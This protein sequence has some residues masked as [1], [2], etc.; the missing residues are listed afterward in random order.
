LG[1]SSSL[2]QPL[3]RIY[4]ENDPLQRETF[5]NIA[6][7]LVENFSK[8]RNVRSQ[9]AIHIRRMKELEAQVA[10][11]DSMS[12]VEA[13]LLDVSSLAEQ[14]NNDIN[15]SIVASTESVTEKT[16]TSVVVQYKKHIHDDDGENDVEILNPRNGEG[17]TVDPSDLRPVLKSIGQKKELLYVTNA[18]AACLAGFGGHGVCEV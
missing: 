11:D 10:V 9:R 15:S 8:L 7:T 17:V 1:H 6:K 12:S 13:G 2:L 3:A 5:R 14:E 4:K 16:S 18:I